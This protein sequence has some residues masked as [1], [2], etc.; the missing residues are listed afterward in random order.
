MLQLPLASRA[1]P[2]EL[3]ALR[4]RSGDANA[5]P[6]PGTTGSPLRSCRCANW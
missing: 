2:E 6:E 5:L 4:V 3:L 1:T